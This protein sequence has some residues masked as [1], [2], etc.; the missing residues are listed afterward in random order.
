MRA[1]RPTI[2]IDTK[3]GYVLDTANYHDLVILN[4]GVRYDDY[5]LNMSG[6]GTQNGRACLATQQAEFGIPN[7][8]LGLTLKPLP[9]GSV[10]VAY[11]TSA[12]PGRRRIR[13]HQ[14]GLWR[15]FPGS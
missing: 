11:A 10:Y 9:N 7:F 14:H 8:N 12:N 4:G 6:F 3:S 1:G 5:N 13:R 15:P 2:G